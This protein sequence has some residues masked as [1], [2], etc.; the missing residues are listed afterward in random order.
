[1]LELQI[2][3]AS[4]VFYTLFTFLIFGIVI[5]VYMNSRGSSKKIADKDFLVLC[6]RQKN[7]DGY[8]GTID[9][10]KYLG[11]TAICATDLR[12][13]GTV[14]VEGTPLDVVTEG[15]FIKKGSTVKII[16][17]DGS[18]ILVRQI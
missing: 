8:T 4:I 3:S 9:K 13:A 12:P 11:L 6:E 18:R 16:N 15:T 7:D 14:T 10:Q 5:V 17:V 2:F 1:M